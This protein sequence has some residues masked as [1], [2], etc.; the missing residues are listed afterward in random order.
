MKNGDRWLLMLLARG[1]ISLGFL[2]RDMTWFENGCGAYFGSN[3]LGRDHVLLFCHFGHNKS[4]QIAP[5]HV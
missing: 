2:N 3:H 4:S 5:K 1:C